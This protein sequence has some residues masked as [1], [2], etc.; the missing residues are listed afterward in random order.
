[1]SKEKKQPPVPEL[2]EQVAEPS[3]PPLTELE[4]ELSLTCLRY[5]RGDWDQYVDF[6]TG[7]RTTEA[8][9]RRELPIVQRLRERDDRSDYLASLLED[10]VV[11]AAEHLDFD[12]LYR[13]WEMCL[14]LDPANEPFGV[15]DS[16]RPPVQP[17]SGEPPSL[18]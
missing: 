16:D 5:F 10:E 12:G 11:T 17:A 9:R 3:F 18:H 4:E 7:A 15:A 1:M 6:L 2:E 8:Q 13:L 14:L